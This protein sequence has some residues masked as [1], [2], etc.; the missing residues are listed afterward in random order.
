MHATNKE[1]YFFICLLAALA[2]FLVALA[3]IRYR[4]HEAAVSRVSWPSPTEIQH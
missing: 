4:Q 2:G 1:R 3:A